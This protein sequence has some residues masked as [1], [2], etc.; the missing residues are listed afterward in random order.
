[1]GLEMTS[2]TEP[3]TARL[4]PTYAQNGQQK[5]W[6]KAPE[7]ARAQ[8]PPAPIADAE[9]QKLV[10]DPKKRAASRRDLASTCMMLDQAAD[11]ITRLAGEKAALQ[12]QLAAAT[13]DRDRLKASFSDLS[14]NINSYINQVLEQ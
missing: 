7:T 11:T 1:M 6:Q 9:V 14:A 8:E 2:P 12:Q 4:V 13:L 10:A 3:R 5:G